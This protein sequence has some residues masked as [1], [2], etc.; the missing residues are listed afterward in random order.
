MLKLTSLGGV[1]TVTG[2]KHLL[3]HDGK[4]ILIDCGLFQ[5]LKNLR[6]LNWEP[7][8]IAPSSIDTVVLTHAHLDHSGYLPKLV[9]DGFRGKIFATDATRAVAK[10]ILRDSGYLQE[11][12]AEY[13]NRK[14]FSKPCHSTEFTMQN[15]RWSA[16]LQFRS[17]RVFNFPAG[18]P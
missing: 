11:K 5:G 2:S 4:R 15:G 3:E 14:G 12:D 8:P 9:K 18:R 7:L 1:G 6:E 10:L 16:S 13:A 17:T